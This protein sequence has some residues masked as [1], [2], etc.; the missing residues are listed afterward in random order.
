VNQVRLKSRLDQ[1]VESCVKAVGVKLNVS[2]THLLRYVSGIGPSRAENVVHYRKQNGNFS[3][4]EDVLKVDR[5]GA[6]AY[7]QCAG[8]L[9][10]HQAQNPLDNSG[11]HPEAYPLVEKMAGDLKV[12]VAE[13]AGNENL[14]K[15]IKAADYIDEAFGKHT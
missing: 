2:G 5:L 3:S 10:I 8:F 11:V 1:T 14:I 9:R 7:E 4:R 15:E 13:L 6:G 12:S